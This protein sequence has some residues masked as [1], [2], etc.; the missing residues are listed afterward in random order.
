LAAYIDL[1][2]STLFEL[3]TTNELTESLSIGASLQKTLYTKYT[4]EMRIW[5]QIIPLGKS[6]G[7]RISA[8]ISGK[9]IA[10]SRVIVKN[11]RMI[12]SIF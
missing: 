6:M 1:G 5:A 11:R 7:L 8:I 2:S 10:P 12:S 9:I 4:T 3:T